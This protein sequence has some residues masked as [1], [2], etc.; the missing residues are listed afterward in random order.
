MTSNL[1]HISSEKYTSLVVGTLDY[2]IKYY[3]GEFV[4][5]GFDC[6][7]EHYQ[8]QQIQASKYGKQGNVKKLE[9][10]LDKYTDRLLQNADLG[11][12]EYIKKRT[13]YDL[14]LFKDLISFGEE[15][16]SRGEIRDEAESRKVMA[17]LKINEKMNYDVGKEK[18][19]TSL[20]DA[21]SRLMSLRQQQ[22]PLISKVSR[23]EER[24][25]ETVEIVEISYGPRPKHSKNSE[26]VSPDAKRRIYISEWM[27]NNGEQANTSVNISFK[28]SSGGIYAVE[29]IWPELNAFWKDNNTVVIETDKDYTIL[30]Q[31]HLMQ[32]FDDVVKVEYVERNRDGI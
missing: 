8:Q 30:S 23:I 24:D 6:V 17:L 5:D 14:D 1:R 4:C 31:Y 16:L 22:N 26:V 15:V 11:F 10:L 32:S 2:L 21:F 12:T 7:K 28:T 9:Q 20:L 29:G 18:Q 13:G 19:L 27:H 25:G 3:T